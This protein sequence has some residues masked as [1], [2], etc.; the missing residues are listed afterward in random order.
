MSY[1]NPY[2]ISINKFLVTL[3]NRDGLYDLIPANNDNIYAISRYGNVAGTA[4]NFLWLINSDTKTAPVPLSTGINVGTSGG[5]RSKF[6]LY[7]NFLI[8]VN[9]GAGNS[10]IRWWK[11]TPQLS[12]T[13]YLNTTLTISGIALKDDYVYYLCRTDFKIYKSQLTIS[14]GTLSMTSPVVAAGGSETYSVTPVPAFSSTLK[15]I[16]NRSFYTNSGQITF[17]AEGALYVT[18]DVD[19]VYKYA[20]GFTPDTTPTNIIPYYECYLNNIVYSKWHNLLYV[21]NLTTGNIDLFTTEGVLV[22]SSYL[23]KTPALQCWDTATSGRG[24]GIVPMAFDSMDNFYYTGGSSAGNVC[25]VNKVICFKKDTK[26]LTMT[27][28]KLIQDLRKGDLVKTLKDGYVPIYKIGFSEMTHVC[29]EERVK[30]QL[31][32]CSPD[33][34]PEVFEDLVLTGCHCILVDSFHSEEQKEKTV[35]L[36]GDLYI[37]DDKY[38]LPVCLDER[39]S[40]YEVPGTHTIYH[41]ALENDEYTF[42]YGIYANGLLVES[43]SK[44]DMDTIR[45]KELT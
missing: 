40:V 10:E 33:N 28:Y 7:Y 38:R 35:K 15:P 9:T 12:T 42:N 3:A 43:T 4:G 21:A 24:L 25:I 14:N 5:L 29:T 16:P 23:S 1:I 13:S 36:N 2:E 39:S 26:I 8:S 18:T 19:G 11:S 37:T 44:K 34:Y 31:Y 41:V 27:G 32:K 45:M 22:L 20:A 17:D 6:V 30:Y